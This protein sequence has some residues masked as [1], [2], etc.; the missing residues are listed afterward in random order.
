MDYGLIKATMSVLSFVVVLIVAIA[1]WIAFQK[2]TKN[3]LHHLDIDLKDVK[4]DVKTNTTNI[5]KIDKNIAII[6]TKLECKL[7]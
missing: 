1:G 2:I 7:D 4:A 6:A 3:H 5:V